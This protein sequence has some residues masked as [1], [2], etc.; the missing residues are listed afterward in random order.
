MHQIIKLCGV[1]VEQVT[2]VTRAV[3]RHKTVVL[4]QAPVQMKHSKET[5][6]AA[7]WG[8]DENADIQSFGPKIISSKR[9]SNGLYVMIITI[10][11]VLKGGVGDANRDNYYNVEIRMSRSALNDI[12]AALEV[13][14]QETTVTPA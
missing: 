10:P 4:P 8:R 3:E 2:A 13:F 14:P 7:V 6:Q 5:I 9:G 1:N 12:Y 11:M